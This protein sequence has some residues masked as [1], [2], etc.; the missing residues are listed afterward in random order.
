[1]R[2]DD[3]WRASR[4]HGWGYAASVRAWVHAAGGVAREY[5]G[6]T[7][8]SSMSHMSQYLCVCVCVCACVCV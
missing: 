8:E 3:V 2:C 4:E 5:L 1:M 6:A 7:L